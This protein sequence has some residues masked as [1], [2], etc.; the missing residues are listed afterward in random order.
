MMVPRGPRSLYGLL[1]LSFTPADDG[2]FRLSVPDAGGEPLRM[3]N[4]LEPLGLRSDRYAPGLPSEFAE[5]VFQAADALGAVGQLAPGAAVVRWAVHGEASSSG[6]AFWYLA[7]IALRL[8]AL[9][10]STLTS[11]HVLAMFDEPLP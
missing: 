11:P 2:V 9:R 5:Y 8:T 1:G 3:D 6:P 7:S 4:T 10:P